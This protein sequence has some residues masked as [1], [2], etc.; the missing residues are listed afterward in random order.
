MQQEALIPHTGGVD[1]GLDC[2]LPVF[3]WEFVPHDALPRNGLLTFFL[4]LPSIKMFAIC[5]CVCLT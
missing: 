2:E 3:C 5:E 4:D 1:Q